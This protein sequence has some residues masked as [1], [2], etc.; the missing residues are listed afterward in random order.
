MEMKNLPLYLCFVLSLII[1]P[2]VSASLIYTGD[3]DHAGSWQLD[4]AYGWYA[5]VSF[6]SDVNVSG[7]FFDVIADNEKSSTATITGSIT[8]GSTPAPYNGPFLST[9]LFQLSDPSGWNG[10]D[11]L[12]IILPR[13]SYWFGFTT[14]D[15]SGFDGQVYH[16]GT[17]GSVERYGLYSMA[18]DWFSSVIPNEN[19][20]YFD[21]GLRITGSHVAVGEPIGMVFIIVI[22]TAFSLMRRQSR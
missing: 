10:A 1:A 3:R 9:F 11:G 6:D 13:G 16:P 8:S 7:V 2:R 17:E 22:A 4:G 19:H 15:L 20:W 5:L 14:P 18:D 21:L 12:N